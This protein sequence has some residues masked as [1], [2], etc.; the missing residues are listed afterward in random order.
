MILI[1]RLSTNARPDVSTT[2]LIMYTHNNCQPRISYFSKCSDD[3]HELTVQS[4]LDLVLGTNVLLI[5][6]N[7]DLSSGPIYNGLIVSLSCFTLSI[8]VRHSHSVTASYV[9]PYTETYVH[10]KCTLSKRDMN[11]CRCLINKRDPLCIQ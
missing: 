4:L 9:C 1:Q 2:I 7:P 11:T 5:Q 8:C 3:L 10:N 6:H